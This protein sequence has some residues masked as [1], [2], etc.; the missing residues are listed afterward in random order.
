MK[1][2]MPVNIFMQC[3]QKWQSATSLGLFIFLD[4]SLPVPAAEFRP[5]VLIQ[6]R[7]SFNHRY[8][9]GI[10]GQQVIPLRFLNDR[11]RVIFGGINLYMLSDSP[12]LHKIPIAPA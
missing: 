3:Q 9:I 7:R 5:T 2:K 1:N 11:L 12:A 10:E 6:S 8:R 4:R